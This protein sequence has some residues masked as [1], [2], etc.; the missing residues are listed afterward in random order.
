MED[1]REKIMSE[2]Y[3][4]I[5]VDY[6]MDFG[7]SYLKRTG[8]C[9]QP[10]AEELGILYVSTIYVN[11]LNSSKYRYT[12]IPKCYGLQQIG[13][14][15]LSYEQTGSLRAQNPPLSLTGKEVLIGFIDT[16][17]RYSLPVFQNKNGTSKVL[18]VWDQADQSGELPED[19]LYGSEYLGDT[20]YR[21]RMLEGRQT[22]GD[23][24][25]MYLEHAGRN[26]DRNGHGTAAASV[27]VSCAPDAHIVMVKCKQAKQYL[28]EYYEI[29]DGANAYAET[30]IMAGLSY[31]RNVSNKLRLPMV[32][33]ITMGTNMGS[34]GAHSLLDQYIAR[35]GSRRGI[36]VVVGGGNEGNQAH[37]YSAR[38]EGTAV[39]TY[40]DMEINV[41]E[42]TQG[43][44]LEIWGSLPALYTISMRSPDGEEIP[45]ISIR[46]GQT[47]E[48][49]F[50]YNE[51]LVRV[52]YLL[53]ERGSAQQLI[54]VRFSNPLDGIW[55]IRVYKD[56]Q[57]PEG[58]FHAWLPITEFVNRPVYFLRSDPYSTMTEPSYVDEGISLTY[59]EA[60]TGSFAIDSGRGYG[61][62]G[63]QFF[64][65]QVPDLSAPGI[66]VETA[67]GK[68]SG[69]SMATA[70]TGGCAA[71]F[72]EWAVTRGQDPLV[73]SKGV[74]NYFIRG[75]SRELRQE[76]PNPTWGYG[77]ISLTGIFDVLKG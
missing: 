70:L 43:F 20:P 59:Y 35:L 39:E 3:A 56:Q 38:I 19:F 8:N 47:Q 58:S 40:E 36:C 41:S 26:L 33:C 67:L 15:D 2:D 1:C 5:L 30:D 6:A 4:D 68:R 69:S 16:G 24:Q 76:Y 11:A 60:A 54:S 10:L 77:K 21:Q 61:D 53:V 18:A 46:Y 45:R 34:H 64:G 72:L 7:E 62:D 37:H 42:G 51:T 32:I 66:N 57:N 75:A 74:K 50:I 55:S 13:Q 28:R 12:Y 14:G 65:L 49:S 71:Q 25:E 48:Y 73:N 27:A 44:S 29:A 22:E 63:R 9:Y 17:I 52:D 31:L 23:V